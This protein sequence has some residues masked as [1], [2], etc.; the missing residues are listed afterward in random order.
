MMKFNQ[1]FEEKAYNA[2]IF[3]FIIKILYILFNIKNFT[4]SRFFGE[5]LATVIIFLILM[6]IAS[7]FS[8]KG[9]WSGSSGSAVLVKESVFDRL[10][11]QYRELAEKYEDEKNYKKAS[12]IYL[13]LLKDSYKA[14]EVL[15]RGKLYHEA[16]A[17][18]LK[19]CENKDKAAAC[20][21]LARAYKEA[22][23]LYAQL[24]DSERLGDIHLL[25]N[26]RKEANKHYFKVIDNYKENSQYVKASLVYKNKINDT[27]EAQKLLLN[28]WKTNKDGYN[29]LNNYF[30]NI[31]DNEELKHEIASIYQNETSSENQESFLQLMKIEFKKDKDLEELTKDIAYE[32]IASQIETKPDISSELVYFNK[33]NKTISKDIMKYKLNKRKRN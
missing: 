10:Q 9:S 31:K 30:E 29:C 15:E 4:P 8:G 32:I 26:D 6:T 16:A 21:Q 7:N 5:V 11:R 23:K 33:I 13:R 19:Y 27:S 1:T 20:Y 2:V 22:I 25:L 24:G 18:Y 17:V 3:L 28:G 14:A 12:Y